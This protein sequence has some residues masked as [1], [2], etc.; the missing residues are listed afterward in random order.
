MGGQQDETG[1]KCGCAN[2]KKVGEGGKL[3]KSRGMGRKRGKK[4]A[5]VK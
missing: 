4:V 1:R 5:V 3:Q 2:G